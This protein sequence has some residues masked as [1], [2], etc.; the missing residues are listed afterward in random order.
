MFLVLGTLLVSVGTAVAGP[1]GFVA[2]AAPHLARHLTGSAQAGPVVS[3]LMGAVLLAGSDVVGRHVL[4]DLPVGVVTAC[5]GGVFFV[6][7]LAR[8]ARLG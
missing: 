7:L 2:L 4:P 8:Q 1:I 3:G 5:L 6:G